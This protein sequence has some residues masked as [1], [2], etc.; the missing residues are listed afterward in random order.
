MSTLLILVKREAETEEEYQSWCKDVRVL[1]TGR[2]SCSATPYRNEESGL[3]GWFFKFYG[4][5]V[6]AL[7]GQTALGG[8][9]EKCIVCRGGEEGDPDDLVGY[10]LAQSKWN[11]PSIVTKRRGDS[12]EEESSG[13]E[14]KKKKK[15]Q[16]SPFGDKGG[17]KHR[18]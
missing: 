2:W 10:A 7:T 6:S 16:K 15:W 13:E 9:S 14:R 8:L 3:A 17:Y 5:K 4:F 18:N 11:V 12:S 1:I